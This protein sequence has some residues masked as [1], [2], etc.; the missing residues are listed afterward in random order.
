MP[1]AHRYTDV[2]PTL[3]GS[4]A[5]VGAPV[6]PAAAIVMLAGGLGLLAGAVTRSWRRRRAPAQRGRV[7]VPS[8][9]DTRQDAALIGAERF[10][11][12]GDDDVTG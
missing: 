10:P 9:T 1:E 7:H 6:L 3:G 8:H 5:N 4:R 12:K 11:R 2:S